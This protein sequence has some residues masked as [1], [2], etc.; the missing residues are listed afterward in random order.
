LN[1]QLAALFA[2]DFFGPLPIQ[3]GTSD[4]PRHPDLIEHS[5]TEM[6]RMRVFG[7]LAGYDDQ[8]DHDTLRTDAIFKLIVN[9]SPTDADLASQP[10]LSRFENQINIA[11]L[12]RLRSVFVDQFIAS[13]AEPPLSLTFDLDAVDDPTYNRPVEAIRDWDRAIELDEGFRRNDIRLQRASCLAQAGEHARAVAE[14]N[15]LS[16]GG[17]MRCRPWHARWV[18]SSSTGRRWGPP[19]AGRRG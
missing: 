17:G 18:A 2:F 11:S 9:R 4:D 12:K 3:I 5:F 19:A 16:E 13:F 8:N 14:A 6:V 15:T 7:I 1:R 10:T